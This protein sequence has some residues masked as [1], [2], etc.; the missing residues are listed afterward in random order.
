MITR[1]IFV[2]LLLFN[3]NLS[4]SQ[5]PKPECK[6]KVKVPKA[7]FYDHIET[8]PNIAQDTTAKKFLNNWAKRKSYLVFGNYI[9]VLCREFDNDY[10]FVHYKNRKGIITK[11]YISSSD[12]EMQ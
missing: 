8:I 3:I 7:Y 10:V 11:G 5:S 9:T 6:F 12:L 2:T 1:I 4:F